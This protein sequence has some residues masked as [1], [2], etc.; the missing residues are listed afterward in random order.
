MYNVTL[1]VR[2]LKLKFGYLN[3]GTLYEVAEIVLG[4]NFVGNSEKKSPKES[5]L[6]ELIK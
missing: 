1:D 2:V 3:L 6:C 4:G 5:N